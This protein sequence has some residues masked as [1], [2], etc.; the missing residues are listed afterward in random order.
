MNEGS[1]MSYCNI[2]VDVY[3]KLKTIQLRKSYFN[4]FVKNIALWSGFLIRKFGYHLQH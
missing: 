2:L 4:S 1:R 3:N